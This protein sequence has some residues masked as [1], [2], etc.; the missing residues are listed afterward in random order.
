MSVSIDKAFEYLNKINNNDRT[1][2]FL[3]NKYKL[4]QK[5]DVQIFL[6]LISDKNK[7]DLLENNLINQLSIN[8]RTDYIKNYL[9]KKD[10]K[11]IR[12]EKKSARSKS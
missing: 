5:E 11:V 6:V 12:I 10:K 9:Q 4:N 2:T 1:L 7:R 3:V 8:E